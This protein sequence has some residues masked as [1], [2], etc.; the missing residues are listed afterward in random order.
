MWLTFLGHP[1]YI[2]DRKFATCRKYNRPTLRDTTCAR[3]LARQMYS[4]TQ[5][6][7]TFLYAF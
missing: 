6:I 5:K 7:G 1:V 4:V 2:T 3:V